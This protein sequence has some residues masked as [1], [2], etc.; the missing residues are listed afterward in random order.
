LQMSRV[1]SD[2]TNF[3]PAGKKVLRHYVSSVAACS[4]NNVHIGLHS[5]IGCG[6]PGLGSTQKGSGRGNVFSEWETTFRK[7]GLS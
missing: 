1:S 2:D 5:Q 3:L 7:N 6:R 4:K